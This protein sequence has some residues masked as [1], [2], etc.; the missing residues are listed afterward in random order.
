MTIS[1]KNLIASEIAEF[2]FK[3]KSMFTRKDKESSYMRM[4]TDC[5]KWIQVRVST[6]FE[7][8]DR[9]QMCDIYLNYV[10]NE[11]ALDLF[12]NFIYYNFFCQFF[13]ILIL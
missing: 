10:N 7:N 6:H 13:S 2:I 8:E 1:E 4:Y 12:K 9:R 5:E 3:D 11:N